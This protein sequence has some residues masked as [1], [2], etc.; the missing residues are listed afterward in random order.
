MLVCAPNSAL[1]RSGNLSRSWCSKLALI[2][3]QFRQFI[4]SLCR[5]EANCALKD[6]AI[7]HQIV[8]SNVLVA[9][10]KM[11][12]E[13]MRC[14]SLY[15]ALLLTML[16][17]VYPVRSGFRGPCTTYSSQA[18]CGPVYRTSG[19]AELPACNLRAD[20]SKVDA[21]FAI[22]GDM[23]LSSAYCEG[24]V[25]DLLKRL[26]KQFG[27]MDFVMALGDVNY[28]DGA[29]DSFENNV[30]QYYGRYFQSG[31]CETPTDVKRTVIPPEEELEARLLYPSAGA[32]IFRPHS[33]P[34]HKQS[35]R[36]W[37]TIGNHDWDKYKV[38]AAH[39]PFFCSCVW[40]WMMVSRCRSDIN[41]LV[42]TRTE[43]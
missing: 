18:G 29:C 12:V 22:I 40:C 38:S 1:R 24:H 39:A 37:P 3:I 25:A 19:S 32:K 7:S 41:P 6:P 35:N 16:F 26:E 2:T 9:F 27:A 11:A 42:V 20:G 5:N 4:R 10:W 34:F 21:R 33:K 15:S 28:W 30:A 17:C 36:F 43:G 23:G 14:M 8:S 13:A 31:A